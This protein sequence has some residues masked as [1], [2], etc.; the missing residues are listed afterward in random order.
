[1]ALERLFGTRGGRDLPPTVLRQF[2]LGGWREP[3]GSGLG[4][5]AIQNPGNWTDVTGEIP[6]R[7]VQHHPAAGPSDAVGSHD[8]RTGAQRERLAGLAARAVRFTA[9]GIGSRDGQRKDQGRVHERNGQDRNSHRFISCPIYGLPNTNLRTGGYFQRNA[10]RPIVAGPD[11]LYDMASGCH[12]RSWS[13]PTDMA[14]PC[15]GTPKPD[16]VA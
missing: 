9:N 5:I 6:G 12:G 11:T 13:H 14:S 15:L 16:A 3:V 8:A 7:V 4:G 2:L 1:M 10:H